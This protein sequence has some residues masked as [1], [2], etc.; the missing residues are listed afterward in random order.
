MKLLIKTLNETAK[1]MYENH[2]HFHEGDAGLD[3]YVLEELKFLPGET[4][5]IKLGI[6][7]QPTD[8][9]AYY[10]FPRSSISKTPLRMSNSIGL[11][12]G[13]YRG[14]IMASCDN[15]KDKE[16]IIKKGQ[17]LFQLVATDSS[18][19]TYKIVDILEKTSRGKGGFGSTGK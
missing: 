10:L 9:K 7:C 19:I 18:S 6:S 14:E 12:D 2:G 3:L 16:Y 5:L 4:H 11:I 15:I 17:R 8:G 1:E 13:G